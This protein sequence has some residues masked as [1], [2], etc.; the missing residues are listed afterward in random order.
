MKKPAAAAPPV[1]APPA[2]AP[3]AAPA[4][5]PVDDVPSKAGLGD[6]GDLLLKKRA[7]WWFQIFFMFTPIWGRFPF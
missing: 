7:R 5:R 6:L 2:P 4:P 1:A 3:P